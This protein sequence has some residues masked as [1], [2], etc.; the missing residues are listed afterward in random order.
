MMSKID[1]YD[2]KTFEDIKHI[3]ENGNEYWFARELQVVLE[4]KEWRNF[5]KSINKALIS[6]KNSNNN[7]YDWVVELNKPITTGKGRIEFIKEYKLS[8]YACY[9][10]VQ[11]G[12]PRKEVIALGQ[13][14]FIMRDTKDYIMEKQQMI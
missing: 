1:K 7:V 11:N 4:Y 5:E 6:M 9:L 13:T 3:D 2:F 12:D 8:R 10:I 14:Y